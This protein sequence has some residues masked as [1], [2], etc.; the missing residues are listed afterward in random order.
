[1]SQEIQNII[2]MGKSGAG[3][4]PRIEVLM[5]EFGLSQLS[6]GNIFREYL[7]SF[8]SINYGGDLSEFYRPSTGSFLPDGDIEA[9]LRAHCET[10][11]IVVEYM[12]AVILGAK[13]KYFIDNGKFVPDYITNAL[14]ESYF[15]RTGYKGAVLDGYPRTGDQ[16]RFL[17]GLVKEK[18]TRIDL[19]VLVDN[20]DEAIVKRTIGR[21]ICPNKECAK[22]YHMEYKPPDGGK[23][24]SACGAEVILRSDDTGERIRSRLREFMEKCVPA[25]KYLEGLGIPRATVPG[26]LPV[27]TEEAVHESV[28][29]AIRPILAGIHEIHEKPL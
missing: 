24:C 22:V 4:Q 23:Y 26:N 7:G 11:A 3:K 8:N 16:A 12:G 1:M 9:K 10:N 28:M 17:A 20:D 29:E 13:A 2:V 6:T 19:V 14:F 27:F 5:K 25:L 15:A 21:R 18:G